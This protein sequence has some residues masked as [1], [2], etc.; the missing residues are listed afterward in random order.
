MLEWLTRPPFTRRANF[1]TGPILIIG[2]V[3]TDSE[4][5]LAK[6]VRAQHADAALMSIDQTYRTGTVA[7]ASPG[8]LWGIP[9]THTDISA[10]L[11]K[12][13]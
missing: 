8:V 2:S 9:L 7:V 12:F 11:I 1:R 6:A 3:T 5:N 4:G 13:R 10:Q